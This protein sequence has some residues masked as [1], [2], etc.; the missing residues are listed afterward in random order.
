[1]KTLKVY[2]EAW[3]L[4]SPFVISRGARSEACVVVVEIEEEGIKGVGECTPYPR[5]GETPA[6]VMAQIMALGPEI[7][8]GMTREALQAALPP[9]GGSQCRGLR[10]LG[11]CRPSAGD[12]PGASGG[13]HAPTKPHNGSDSG[14]WRAR[15][16]GRQR[17]GA[18]R[19][20][21]KI[22]EGQTGRSPDKR[23]DDCDPCRSTRGYADCR[24]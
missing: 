2:E 14:H 5:Y 20:R 11:S 19:G 15:A 12:A 18:L 9:R 4:H 23:T 22:A 8:Q 10:T 24:C 21:S 6:S 13:C 16:D 17:P 7:E 3:P 1:M